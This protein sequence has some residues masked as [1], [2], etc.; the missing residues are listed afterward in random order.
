[1]VAINQLGIATSLINTL[2]VG[3]VGALALASGLAFGLGGRDRAAQLLD[4]MGRRAEEAGPRLERAASAAG[5]EA[6]SA[7]RDAA[8]TVERAGRGEFEEDWTPR[9]EADRRRVVRPGADRRA[10]GNGGR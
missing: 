8:R 7:A 6:R 9:A 5:R 2:L 4:R 10:A 3:V 1:M